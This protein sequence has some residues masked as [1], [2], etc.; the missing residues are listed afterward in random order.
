VT[1]TFGLRNRVL[2]LILVLAAAGAGLMVLNRLQPSED[3]SPVPPARSSKGH[4]A[5]KAAAKPVGRAAAKPASTPKPAARHARPSV[6]PALPARDRLPAA[7]QQALSANRVVVVALYDPR[8][9]IDDTALREA[10]AGAQLA[11][12]AFVPVD[13]T[14][15]EVDS[16]NARYGVIQDP[17]VLVLRPPGDL[18]VRI[19]GFADRDTVAQAAANAAS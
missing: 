18:I 6:A 5:T 15:N 16:L 14:K 7:I 11:R 8:A 2:L 13:V 10:T 1:L 19:D 3:S 9:K 17:A 12:T 4:S